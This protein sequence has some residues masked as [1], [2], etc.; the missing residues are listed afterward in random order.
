MSGN[1]MIFVLVAAL[2][3]CGPKAETG[4]QEPS[5][6]DEGE[7]AVA[8]EEASGEAVAL[9]A[10]SGVADDG[11]EGPA[12]H[13][14]EIVGSASQK[15]VEPAKQIEYDV[16][17]E[18]QFDPSPGPE[19]KQAVMQDVADAG[20]GITMC[21]RKLVLDD[22]SLQGKM[23]VTVKIGPGG[24]GKPVKVIENATGS[25]ALSACVVKDLAKAQY[26][27]KLAGSKPLLLTVELTFSPVMD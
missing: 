24:V 12:G 18:M 22:P 1:K 2:A 16:D 17:V 4:V 25:D 8:A 19:G 13:P 3:A 14:T 10:G 26:P 7:A 11:E 6:A 15:E 5:K 23:K 20:V 9:D 27:K 21:Y